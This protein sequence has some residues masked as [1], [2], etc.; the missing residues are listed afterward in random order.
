[1]TKD[2][3]QCEKDEYE[4]EIS[5][6]RNLIAN[7]KCGSTEIMEIKNELEALHSKEVKNYEHILKKSVL[8]LKRSE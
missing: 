7:I 6:L 3:K 2:E 8:I 4:G 5:R 1:M